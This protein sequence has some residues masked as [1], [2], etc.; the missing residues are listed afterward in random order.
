[1]GQSWDEIENSVNT[2]IHGSS[3]LAS[4]GGD[5]GLQ[6][7]RTDSNDPQDPGIYPHGESASDGKPRQ[8][9]LSAHEDPERAAQDST[10]HT[11]RWLIESEE[12]QAQC[13]RSCENGA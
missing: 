13:L 10:T 12:N 3:T 9:G 7:G 4:E 8:I 1:M 6:A 2:M 11:S 5:S